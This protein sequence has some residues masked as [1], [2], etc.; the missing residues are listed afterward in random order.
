MA[1]KHP[2]QDCYPPPTH[3]DVDAAAARMNIVLPENY[4]QILLHYNGGYFHHDESV[5]CGIEGAPSDADVTL[6]TWYGV[7]LPESDSGNIEY[8]RSRTLGWQ[9]RVPP[10]LLAIASGEGYRNA[11]NV[12]LGCD[13]EYWGKVYVWWFQEAG[14]DDDLELWST[15]LEDILA[16]IYESWV[17]QFST[18]RDPLFRGI[19]RG[20]TEVV[21][22]YLLEDG[23]P[24]RLSPDSNWPLLIV[25]IY[26]R[27][28]DVINLLLE[29][30]ASLECRDADRGATPLHWAA[31]SHSVDGTKILLAA[32]RT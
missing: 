13:G 1:L 23:D 24:N 32:G 7:N 9:N 21:K 5:R 8:G 15:S 22:S 20:F 18:E 27:R 19:E 11:C 14:A 26:Y 25:A 17:E 2:I 31:T 16:S 4:R 29:Q 28:L 30:G 3:A 6:R 12:L 10:S